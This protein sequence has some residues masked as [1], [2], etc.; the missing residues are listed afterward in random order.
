[1]KLNPKHTL[2]SCVKEILEQDPDFNIVFFLEQEGIVKP[3][4]KFRELSVAD[5]CDK[6][7]LRDDVWETSVIHPKFGKLEKRCVGNIYRKKDNRL[8]KGGWD[9][10][11]SYRTVA[12]SAKSVVTG[13]NI[14]RNVQFHTIAFAL[15]NKRWNDSPVLDHKDDNKLNNTGPNLVEET[16]TTN[17]WQRKANIAMGLIKRTESSV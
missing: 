12:L 2:K 16:Y 3:K 1:M 14:T 15:Y 11:K 10:S 9:G 4:R 5:L 7:E 8:M 13:E 6:Y 17:Q